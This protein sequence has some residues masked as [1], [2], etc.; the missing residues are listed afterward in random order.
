MASIV[1]RKGDTFDLLARRAYGDDKQSTL[2]RSAN[3]GAV[4]PFEAGVALTVPGQPGAPQTAPPKTQADNLN[5][6]A[7]LINGQRFRYWTDVS[8]KRSIDSMDTLSL[9]APF[10]PG[11]R[12]FRA[13][14]KPFSFLPVS[15]NVGGS[16]LFAGTMLTVDPDV[17][18][19]SRTVSAGCYSSPAVLGDCTAPAS[20]YPL[21]WNDVGLRIIATAVAAPFGVPVVFDADEGAVFKR[22]ALKPG[23][24][25]LPFLV[26]LAQQRGLLVSSTEQG[27]LS[28]KKSTRAG[29][30]VA[31]LVEGASPLVDVSPTFNPQE[32][33]SEITG[34]EPVLIGLKGGQTTVRNPRLRTSVRP[35]TFEA[36][37]TINADLNAACQAKA[38]RMFANT[39]HYAC[40]VAT[41]RDSS[42]RLWE[43][44][45]LVS[46]D[47]PG[48][49]V[50]GAYEFL[51][52]SVTLTRTSDG[53]DVATLGLTIPG[54]FNSE[55]PDRL[56]WGEG[57]I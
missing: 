15:V 3:P 7:L 11:D 12:F 27:A 17:G 42:G 8:I 33:Y 47:A 56:P 20:A 37:D 18:A 50:Y 51:V 46:L 16:P 39:V 31:R 22:V 36:S 13:T 24:K 44:N 30:P 5:E 6:L 9:S 25:I 1:T 23:E 38:A 41:W 35:F 10:D 2:L 57:L 28:F 34:I 32:Y 49:M 43:P 48:A 55:L 45:T 26:K 52:R 19:E 4:E 40:T 21:E 14:F 54:A 53:G 29:R